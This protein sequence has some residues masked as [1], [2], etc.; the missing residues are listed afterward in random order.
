MERYRQEYCLSINSWVFFSS[1]AESSLGVRPES[2][3]LEYPDL[4]CPFTPAT[5]TIKNS[6]RLEPVMARKFRRSIIGLSFSCASS[7]TRALKSI[8]LSSRL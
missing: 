8:Q 6:S 7:S 3:G 1:A 2:S 5:R 4:I